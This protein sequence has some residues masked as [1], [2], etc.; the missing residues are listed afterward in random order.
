[1]SLPIADPAAPLTFMTYNIH[2]GQG[3]DGRVALDR[4]CAV[5]AQARPDV[6]ALQEV[7]SGLTR[8]GWID[9]GA[10]IA[11]ELDMTHTAGHNWF[12]EEGAYGNAVLSRW[13]VTPLGNVD[14]SVAGR[15]PRGCLVT[16]VHADGGDIVVGSVH[17]GLGLRERRRQ[18]ATLLRRF[19]SV[20][21]DAPTILMGDFNALPLSAVCRRFRERFSDAFRA[22]GNGPAGTYRIGSV[23]FR[24]DYIYVT[25]RLR[26][27]EATVSRTAAT[28]M[29]SDHLPV[30]ARV[31]R[32]RSA[33][34]EGP[35]SRTHTLP[36]PTS[37]RRT[38]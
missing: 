15:E 38:D 19:E 16:R 27:L 12:L 10:A 18:C 17:L 4:I 32:K 25:D 23:T 37:V 22:A 21:R 5:I 33:T 3:R 13:P 14:L 8:S 2:H 20:F 36:T 31:E 30:V 24:L 9:Q 29:A 28:R 34:S 7:D 26:P 1:V 11:S 35:P 6:V